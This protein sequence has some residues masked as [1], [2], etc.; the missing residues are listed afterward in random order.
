[1]R[2]PAPLARRIDRLARRAHR[3]HRFAHHPLCDAYSGELISIGRRA[4]ICRGCSMAIAGLAAGLA[5]GACAPLA[6]WRSSA[7]L[8]AASWTMLAGALTVRRRR[9][10]E[11]AVRPPARPR[12]RAKLTTRLLPA[13]LAGA[14]IGQALWAGLATAAVAGAAALA[15]AWTFAKLYRRRGPDR[16][17]CSDCPERLVPVA[18]S[19]LVPI[20]RRERAFR[21]LSG[22]WLAG[23]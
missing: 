8:I 4:R 21:R 17:P 19:G 20:V 16:S 3:F 22:R 10:D 2:V 14:A 7:A 9:P 11:P 13:L 5:A 18:C 23:L 1:M 6:T 12:R 15:G